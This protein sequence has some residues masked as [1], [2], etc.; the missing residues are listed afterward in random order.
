MLDSQI[1]HEELA[2]LTRSMRNSTFRDELSNYVD[3][4]SDPK[5]RLEED[6]FWEESA[7][8][9]SIPTGNAIVKPKAGF[10]AKSSLRL[11]NGAFM[12]FYINVCFS[13]VL[14][15]L[16][17]AKI[18]GGNNVSLPQI[19]S[20]A[21]LDRE[22]NEQGETCQTCVTCVSYKTF[23]MSQAMAEIKEIIIDQ[24]IAIMKKK[25]VGDGECLS[26][27]YQILGMKCKGQSPRFCL[28]PFDYLV[29]DYK[30]FSNKDI[31]Y[32]N[33]VAPSDAPEVVTPQQIESMQ[34]RAKAVDQ[35]NKSKE[36][37]SPLKDDEESS[38]VTQKKK[39]NTAINIKASSS[40]LNPSQ[41]TLV[42]PASFASEEE[43]GCEISIVEGQVI[44]AAAT[45]VP[46]LAADDLQLPKHLTIRIKLPGVTSAANIDCDIFENGSLLKVH[47][48]TLY[49][50][51]KQLPYRVNGC[52]AKAQFIRSSNELVLTIPVVSRLQHSE[53]N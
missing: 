14:K 18:E 8:N 25:Y 44:T 51:E 5:H 9:G 30:K 26:P 52:A 23:M 34:R 24:T 22:E 13:P 33:M 47:V 19:F 31:V 49:A 43:K 7:R 40:T 37:E 21:R 6:Q 41:T 2:K 29:K 12:N 4:R 17:F 20:E 48:P 39:T 16:E 32:P 10:V 11:S 46:L 50:A 1:S 28:C 42:K 45:D 27:D 15:D 36:T 38:L 3:E 53:V 35:A